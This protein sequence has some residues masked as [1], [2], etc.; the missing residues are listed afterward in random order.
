MITKISFKP[1]ARQVSFSG[2]KIE[3]LK[4]ILHNLE[5]KL[6]TTYDAA[7]KFEMQNAINYIKAAIDQ[8]EAK[9]KECLEKYNAR[10]SLEDFNQKMLELMGNISETTKTES[11]KY[12]ARPTVN[13]YNDIE[14]KQTITNT[15]NKE[16][17]GK[18]M[19]NELEMAKLEHFKKELKLAYDPE[20]KF[21]LTEQ[22]SKIQLGKEFDVSIKAG[23]TRKLEFYNKELEVENKKLP[24][25]KEPQ[26]TIN[27]IEGIEEIKKMLSTL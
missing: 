27:L 11:I 24:L 6:I 9:A 21:I 2:G 19:L 25:E 1:Q 16:E 26:K 3:Y 22:I 7:D 17:E 20:H 18:I 4:N 5:L 14:I 8:G 10:K 23:L 15:T 13:Y 12:T